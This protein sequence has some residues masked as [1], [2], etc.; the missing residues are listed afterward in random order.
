MSGKRHPL[1]IDSS[2]ESRSWPVLLLLL[3]VV[4]VPTV[5]VLWFMNEV[6]QNE[7]LAVRRKLTN[8]YRSQ[9][10][11]VR[12]HLRTK[13]WESVEAVDNHPVDAV[14]ATVFHDTV[15]AGLTDSLICYD[16]QAKQTYPQVGLAS[17]VEDDSDDSAWKEANHFE[18]VQKDFLA[19]AN[20][21]AAIER[22]ALSEQP[23]AVSVA[24]R[25]L[26]S[27]ARCYFRA[28]QSE[29]AIQILDESLGRVQFAEAIDLGGRLIV[30]DAELRALEL[31]LETPGTSF[32]T[33]A[34][35]L[36]ARL[37]DYAD[38]RLSASQRLFLMKR[39]QSLIPDK[40]DF[41]TLQ[42]E[43]LAQH[44]LDVRSSPTKD[45]VLQTTS[46]PNVW[47]IASPSGRALLLF[48]TSQLTARMHGWIASQGLPPEV[49]VS[50]LP[51]AS[52]ISSDSV[53]ASL[54]VG[55][56][57][58]G[59]RITL[60]ANDQDF[61]RSATTRRITAY[62]WIGILVIATTTILAAL[63]A[64]AIRKQNQLAKLK[65]DLVA[66]I[67]H[68]LKTP[69]ASMRLLVDTLLDSP[70]WN[71]TLAREYLQLI[72]KENTRLSRLIDNFLAFSRIERNKYRF[73]FVNT[74]VDDIIQESLESV[75]ERFHSAD[76]QFD[77]RID[78]DL[79]P[80]S[81]DRDA[82]VTVVLNL[83][84][85]AY[86]YSDTKKHIVLS[87]F[88]DNDQICIEVRDNGIGLSQHDAKRIFKRFYQADQRLSRGNEGCG[89]G[90]SIVQYIVDAHG[91]TVRVISEPGAGSRFIVNLP[92]VIVGNPSAEKVVA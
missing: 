55:E 15:R 48:E 26:Q 18:Y 60:V 61:F 81:G 49:T 58:P 25:A 76:C 36:R 20:A 37:S 47:Q 77:V 75:Q 3:A 64:R 21:Y 23:S 74:S 44:F 11:L 84:D 7:H 38:R 69:L 40:A 80:V 31:L 10:P 67:S 83:L 34:N 87:A 90:L 50:V 12:E 30:A 5:C 13:F 65:N 51:P 92:A 16:A 72:G 24:A 63:I 91:G 42:A 73:D 33:I 19:A 88:T 35:R 1:R 4:L 14:G 43:E 41:P 17:H 52:E 85:N 6:T 54:N 79:P 82:L 29:K 86:K 9:L 22:D 68:E 70:K 53:I 62:F 2:A 32:A 46:V 28:G 71:E 27:Q 8:V 59:W 57:L 66:T 45:D 39:L 89:L 56:R 78:A